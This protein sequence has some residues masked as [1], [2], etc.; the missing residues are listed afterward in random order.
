MADGSGTDR[1][2]D[3]HHRV[4]SRHFTE[5][6][7]KHDPQLSLGKRFA[8]PKK[9]WTARARR[10]KTRE[11]AR[12]LFS[13]V[14]STSTSGSTSAKDDTAAVSDN[15]AEVEENPLLVAQVGEQLETEYQLHELPTDDSF[16]TATSTE[17]GTVLSSSFTS[18]SAA[19]RST[20]VAT[21]SESTAF[22]D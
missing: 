22:E 17:A 1:C 10:A 11:A 16:S 13:Q 6:D 19:D 9:T 7:A 12:N 15:E 2:I 20:Q 3:R 4:C 18:V 5:G 14:E 8:L 21:S